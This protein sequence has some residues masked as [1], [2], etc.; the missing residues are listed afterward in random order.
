MKGPGRSYVKWKKPDPKKENSSPRGNRRRGR[1]QPNSWLNCQREVKEENNEKASQ[2]EPCQV[3]RARSKHGKF[4]TQKQL[5]KRKQKSQF[6]IEYHQKRR[7]QKEAT[8]KELVRDN[9]SMM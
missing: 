6:W 2:N 5:E 4:I 8:Q 9:G 3:E 1:N 7:E